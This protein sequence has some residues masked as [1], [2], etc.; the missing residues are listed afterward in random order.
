MNTAGL[1][2]II[3]LMAFVIITILLF[4]FVVGHAFGRMDIAAL[5]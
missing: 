5:V 2:G 1:W 3:S 4:K